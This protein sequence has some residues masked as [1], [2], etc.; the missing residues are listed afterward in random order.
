[1]ALFVTL[2]LLS[3]NL[4]WGHKIVVTSKVD[5]PSQVFVFGFHRGCTTFVQRLLN[6]HRDVT[7]WGENVGIFGQLRLLQEKYAQ[8]PARKVDIEKYQDF[9]EFHDHFVAWANPFDGDEFAVQIGHL[10]ESLYVTSPN[11]KGV[12]GF[13]E[14]RDLKLEDINF[15]FK[16]F[17]NCRL[18]LPVRHP[19]DIILSIYF[20]QWGI[21]EFSGSV[22]TTVRRLLKEYLAGIET[23]LEVS[24]QRNHLV[25][26]INIESINYRTSYS[27]LFDLLAL[28]KS[29][30]NRKLFQNVVKT[31]AGSSYNEFA[32]KVKKSESKMIHALTDEMIKSVLPK[33]PR[34]RA[35]CAI[36]SWYPDLPV[37]L[38]KR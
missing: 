10:F 23:F 8:S 16:I 9:S 11:P 12:W 24:D 27:G 22:K 32:R 7:V 6:C 5:Y 34:N 18:V 26:I 3:L 1:M 33:A 19:R 14:I 38:K 4:V 28:P 31:R 21:D 29:G 30:V 17:P 36:H 13:K 35:L 15:L 25:K 37:K 20:S 2:L